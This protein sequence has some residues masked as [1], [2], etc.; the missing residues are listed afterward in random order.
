MTR[1]RITV[2]NTQ[3]LWELLHDRRKPKGPVVSMPLRVLE[4]NGHTVPAEAGFD[5]DGTLVISRIEEENR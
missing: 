2:D 4:A 5:E 3:D 1:V